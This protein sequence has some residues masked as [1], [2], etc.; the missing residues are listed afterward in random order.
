MDNFMFALERPPT[1]LLDIE[2][3]VIPEYIPEDRFSMTVIATFADLDKL[4][5]AAKELQE[6]LA[7]CAAWYASEPSA[8]AQLLDAEA[9]EV[10]LEPPIAD[11]LTARN[12][13]IPSTGIGWLGKVSEAKDAVVRIGSSL[14]V[15]RLKRSYKKLSNGKDGSPLLCGEE[16]DLHHPLVVFFEEFRGEVLVE[17]D[18]CGEGSVVADLTCTCSEAEAHHLI[19]EL[20]QYQG[21]YYY[22]YAIPPWHPKGISA[23]QVRAR[24]TF[25]RLLSGEVPHPDNHLEVLKKYRQRPVVTFFDDYGQWG[26]DIGSHVG[27]LQVVKQ[28]ENWRV[29]SEEL[30]ISG[31][32]MNTHFENQT[33]SLGW[34]SFDSFIY[35]FPSFV[36]YLA[37]HGCTNF[38]YELVD[39]NQVRGD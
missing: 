10:P 6:I 37:K 32:A 31:G 35:G 21:L 25:N 8:Q 9:E 28:G 34:I 2:S 29:A 36:H 12:L 1:F 38:R 7:R 23:D 16:Y 14:C 22:L 4:M 3:L 20:K 39:F 15:H 5:E 26:I 27:Q 18:I 33:L 24:E 19:R 13:A 17:G 30:P 11:W